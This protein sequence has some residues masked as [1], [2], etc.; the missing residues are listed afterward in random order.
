MGGVRT[1]EFDAFGPWI[2]HV[3]SA[4]GL[5]PLY[6][7]HP[8]DVE[9]ARLVLKVPR[10]I[11][12]RD[13]TPDMHL[14]DHLLVAGADDLTVLSRRGDAYDTLVVRYDRIAAIHTSVVMLEGL[15][16]LYATDAAGRD[17]VALDLAYNGVSDDVVR[18]LARIL[19]EQALASAP[20]RPVPPPALP[21]L[22]LGM[23]DLGRN[24][25]ALVSTARELAASEGLAVHAAQLRQTVQH[26]GPLAGL[27]SVVLPTTMHA[28]VVGSTPGEVHLLHRRPWVTSGRRPA[29]SVAHTVIAAPRVDGVEVADHPG[30]AGT[31][32]VRIVAG[33][34]TVTLPCAAG[35]DVLP[36]LLALLGAQ[37]AL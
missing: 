22:R 14:Y 27:W 30:Q 21:V 7:D 4:E 25:V 17:G 3:V 19:R 36:A 29:H 5:P 32:Q 8:V 37:R 26:E 12:R 1:A 13:A 31:Q 24:D 6:R 9:A 28:V 15:L 20:E 35:G 33:R 18:Q 2:M 16:R 23:D 11:A 10:N 34:A